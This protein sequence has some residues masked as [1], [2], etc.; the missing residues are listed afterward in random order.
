LRKTD[1]IIV[2]A[3]SAG[4]AAAV[5]V[6]RSGLQCEVIDSNPYPGGNATAAEVGTIC[7]AYAYDNG[8]NAKFIANGFLKEFTEIIQKN[9]GTETIHEDGLWYL[10]YDTSTY[11]EISL[12]YLENSNISYYFDSKITKIES[13][14]DQIEKVELISNQKKLN[15]YC[16][17]LID[18]SGNGIS[19]KFTQK[20]LIHD[21]QLQAAAL[22]FQL[23]NIKE[24]NEKK[25]AF[26][27]I[28]TLSSGIAKGLLPEYCNR[29]YVVQGSLINE[30]VSLKVGIPIEVSDKPDCNIQLKN[31]GSEMIHLVFHYLK[32]NTEAFK[33]AELEHIADHAGIR[34][35][36]RPLGRYIL[37][38]NDVL[39]CKKFENYIAIGSWPIEI[40]KQSH[41]VEMKYFEPG[42]HYHI[43]ADS[44]R[45]VAFDNLFFAGRNISA[46]AGAIASAR[47]IG[48][49]LQTGYA[50]GILA[51]A[52][53]QNKAESSAILEIQNHLKL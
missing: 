35:S 39:N 14:N 29:V 52:K 40:W 16:K 27:M 13:K 48:T 30:C 6:A 36:P 20:P 43:P 8:E 26:I 53:V 41:R 33:F 18:C 50:A 45:S 19:H 49:C 46:D 15:L 47:V 9:S 23:K 7:G 3:G 37:T 12:K 44:L 34:T 31:I 38:E 24:P 51:A 25:L 42:N 4:V 22:V 10:P 11:K 21:E 5:A 2:G 1:I 17:A 32:N 28:K